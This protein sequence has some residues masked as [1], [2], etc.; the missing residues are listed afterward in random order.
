VAEG[1]GQVVLTGLEVAQDGICK[2]TVLADGYQPGEVSLS[3]QEF[4]TDS[5]L[6]PFALEKQGN[7][8]DTQ[9][10]RKGEPSLLQNLS[11]WIKSV[12]VALAVLLLGLTA[13]TLTSA[14]SF[15]KKAGIEGARTREGLEEISRR[16]A[17]MLERVGDLKT[18]IQELRAGQ[19]DLKAVCAAMATVK[20][21]LGEG[22]EEV[23][24]SR[25]SPGSEPSVPTTQATVAREED[26]QVPF[27]D[28]ARQAYLNIVRGERSSLTS[29]Y[30]NT[31]VV[32]SPRDAFEQRD[33][34]LRE[35][36]TGSFVVFIDLTSD[37]GWVFPHPR[38]LYSSEVYKPVFPNLTEQ[39]FKYSK[40]HIEPVLLTRVGPALWKVARS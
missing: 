27:R 21:G 33:A 23:P 38:R 28:T 29:A 1:A 13:T 24:R 30:L 22:P 35:A 17:E 7:A 36:A 4:G 25:T 26:G 37:Q 5:V 39:Q 9:A 32:S 16:V 15:R 20:Q 18:R 11:T 6:I 14:Q 34:L 2:I 40:E 10:P 19:D 3:T 8:T 12:G 31:E